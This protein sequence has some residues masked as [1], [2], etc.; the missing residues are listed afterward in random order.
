[1]H[2]RG[3]YSHPLYSQVVNKQKRY[4]QLASVVLTFE[5]SRLR[6]LQLLKGNAEPFTLR[7]NSA[8]SLVRGSS[9]YI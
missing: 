6:T 5:S 9:A 7:K 1:M 4:M 3:I 2:P 8:K